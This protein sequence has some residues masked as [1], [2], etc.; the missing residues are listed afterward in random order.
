MESI[1][2][3]LRLPLEYIKY[4]IKWL[5]CATVLGLI[6]GFVGVVFHKGLDTVAELNGNYPWL[7]YLLP[8]GGLVI[9]LMY[10]LSERF[11]KLDTNH[12]VAS[13]Q[14]G[15]KISII[16]MP[17]IFVGTLI[18]H[19]LGGSAGREGA[20]LQLGGSAGYN[21]GKIF[22]FKTNDL[23]IIVMAGMSAVFSALFG[24][25]VTAAIFAV[26]VACVGAINVAAIVPCFISA[27][28]AYGMAVFFGLTPVSFSVEIVNDF[29]Y[30]LL[31]K[32]VLLAF[33]CGL[34][35][36][37]FCLALKKGHIQTKK[38]L[39]NPFLRAI[40][41]GLVIIL[42]TALVGNRDYNGAGMSII[43]RAMN[44]EARI[45]AFLLKMVF[46][47]VTVSTG[48]KGGEI[49]P[50]FFVG[51][52]FGCVVGAIL[53]LNPAFGA[54]IGFVALF[55]GVVNCPFAS[56]LL[57]VEVFGGQ[58][59]IFFAIACGVSFFISGKYSLYSTQHFAFS[60]I[61]GI[62]DSK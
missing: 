7:L 28:S 5:I 62:V 58:G 4:F 6:C 17:L 39:P 24:T 45:E 35:A 1:K 32:T 44:G 21:L 2:K 8:V 51:S 10:F 52:T 60:K 30:V 46:T 41:G 9:A 40:V 61:N 18:T 47:V 49:V 56:I 14:S 12:V 27:L 38:I 26:E 23:K 3:G 34:V 33:L 53:G 31:M 59:L 36:I 54:A 13:A 55:C 29:S 25:P 19:L 22:R 57:S 11:G 15:E 20:A 43:E 42:L 37:V 16:M 48:F 50:T